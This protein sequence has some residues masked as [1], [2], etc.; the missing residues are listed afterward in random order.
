MSNMTD[1][2]AGIGI[3]CCVIASDGEVSEAEMDYLTFTMDHDQA[4]PL[5]ESIFSNLRVYEGDPVVDFAGFALMS[6][7]VGQDLAGSVSVEDAGATLNLQGNRWQAIKLPY[8]ITEQSILDCRRLGA[9]DHE[10]R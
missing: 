6:Y 3:L 7:G 8:R 4:N 1:Q 9:G 10:S 2:Q 5:G